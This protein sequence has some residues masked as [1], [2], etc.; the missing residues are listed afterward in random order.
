MSLLR[1]RTKYF[2]LSSLFWCLTEPTNDSPNLPVF[3]R[4]KEKGIKGE[5]KKSQ[6]LFLV[7]KDDFFF[8]FTRVGRRE[9]GG[10]CFVFVF[11]FSFAFVF[12]MFT[13]HGVWKGSVWGRGGQG[14]GETAASLGT[15]GAQPGRGSRVWVSERGNSVLKE[16]SPVPGHMHL[17]PAMSRVPR[18]PVELGRS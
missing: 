9:G 17:V 2:S 13:V 10:S 15:R 7:K 8:F 11:V 6:I 12:L 3:M 1:I 16:G 14:K 4:K 5:K 18:S